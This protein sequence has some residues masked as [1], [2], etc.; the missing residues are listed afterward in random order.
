MVTK[1]ELDLGAHLVDAQLITKESLDQAVEECRRNPSGIPLLTCLVKMKV[2]KED[3][4][5]ETLAQRLDLPLIRLKD[6]PI[7]KTL[8][9]K[10][11]V[12]FVTHYKFMPTKLASK[13][14]SRGLLT[15]AVASPLN[16]RV[17]DELRLHLG[18]DVETVLTPSEDL[19]T[20]MKKYYGLAADT[21]EKI[22]TTSTKDGSAFIPPE[23]N[24][25]KVEDIEKLA[26]D[27]SVIKLVNQILL[28]GH[29]SRAT[30]IHLEPYRGKIKLRY[31]VD[32]V[33]YDVNVPPAIKNFYPSI[34]SRIKIMSNLNIVERRL[35]QDGRAAVKTDKGNIDLRISVIPTP[36]GESVVIRMLPTRMLYALTD[37]GISLAD[38][39][40]LETLLDKPHGIIFVTGPTGSGKTTTL[41]AS[42]NKL[43]TPD[44]KILTIEDP[45][46]YEME[47]ITQIQVLPEIDL[48]FA[49]GLRSMLRHDP[50]VMMVGEVRD[51]ETAETTIRIA[52]TG[53]LIF[54]TLHTNDA[55][56]GVTRLLDMGVEPFLVA[57]SVE[58]FIAQRLV[59]VICPDCKE[60]DKTAPKELV[61]ELGRVYG[62]GAGRAPKIY[63][64]KGCD[65]C[66]FTGY[67]G[68]TAIY[69]ILLVDEHIR[70]LVLQKSSSEEIKKAAIAGGMKTLRH[71]GWQ[72]ITAGQTTLDEG[73]RVSPSDP[74]PSVASIG[75]KQGGST[76]GA[77]AIAKETAGKHFPDH[78]VGEESDTAQ[79]TYKRLQTRVPLEYALYKTSLNS[80]EE[81]FPKFIKI[82]ATDIS[83]SGVQWLST[84]AV[85]PGA[86]VK[87][88]LY[89]PSVPEI[90]CL[91]RVVRVEEHKAEAGDVHGG[92]KPH[93][94]IA[95]YYLDIESADKAHIDRFIATE[96]MASE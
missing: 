56:G 64:G 18:Y 38:V 1:S 2:V 50:D 63:K 21:I 42:L 23:A 71:D 25:E 60:E 78:S 37:L 88:K 76:A 45:I 57:S 82:V 49:R 12:R 29:K 24:Q 13:P 26:E 74:L 55:A 35:P 93:Y 44:V 67:Q 6:L 73:L 31:R 94:L 46:E 84:E 48:T 19:M 61:A 51:F 40:I 39:K 17:I 83:A 11:P 54:S 58:A 33:L 4:M 16:I 36:Y 72:K 62:I 20:A 65:A 96:M 9:T 92:Q 95:S 70:K 69:E 77:P 66:N 28:E 27:A 79:R 43:N 87:L 34:I 5:L 14:D 68:R 22:L 81:L 7:E 32:G 85:L 59:R 86:I 41:Y 8:I 80:K 75:T 10:I 53:H 15:I 89:L 3:R 47:G 30:D 52:L 91:V 90:E